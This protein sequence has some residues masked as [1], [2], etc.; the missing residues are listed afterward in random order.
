MCETF[1]YIRRFLVA[2]DIHP[3][4]ID[5]HLG[6]TVHFHCSQVCMCA[7]LMLWRMLIREQFR[8]N[9]QLLIRRY[10]LEDGRLRGLSPDSPTSIPFL[11]SCGSFCSN[12]FHLSPFLRPSCTVAL[13]DSLAYLKSY[14]AK[15]MSLSSSRKVKSRWIHLGDAVLRVVNVVLSRDVQL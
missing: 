3:Q 5:H 8:Q 13:P 4:F 6:C 11:S 12:V 1:L 14:T 2:K 15:P 7:H 10:V 9:Q